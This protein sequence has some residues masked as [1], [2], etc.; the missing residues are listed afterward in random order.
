MNEAKIYRAITK[1]IDFDVFA[2]KALPNI[3]LEDLSLDEYKD[4]STDP[5]FISNINLFIHYIAI[6][7]SWQLNQVPS[8]DAKA[9]YTSKDKIEIDVNN[10]DVLYD[11][12]NIVLLEY[13]KYKLDTNV[14]NHI[15]NEFA[16]FCD[17]NSKEIATASKDLRW[18]KGSLVL[19]TSLILYIM[20]S[21]DTDPIT[22]QMLPNAYQS[23][24]IT[25]IIKT[26]SY[27]NVDDPVSICITMN[28]TSALKKQFNIVTSKNNTVWVD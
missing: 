11:I 25:S 7:T 20:D 19:S 15:M 24:G 14:K 6:K 12:G 22:N 28:K 10:T 27:P 21:L 13:N 2:R 9:F 23:S 4:I 16:I 26:Y 5:L 17:K 8:E 1:E 18:Y 3:F